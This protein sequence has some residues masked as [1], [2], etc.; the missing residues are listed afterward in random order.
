MKVYHCLPHKVSRLFAV[1]EQNLDHG[2]QVFALICSGI[3]TCLLPTTLCTKYCVKKEYSHSAFWYFNGS[4]SLRPFPHLRL[5]VPLVGASIVLGGT[6]DES[7]VPQRFFRF[8]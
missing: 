3:C 7:A 6:R 5:E 1:R 4:V 2:S 8:L